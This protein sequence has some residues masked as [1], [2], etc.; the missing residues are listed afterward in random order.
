MSASPSCSN[1]RLMSVLSSLFTVR[2]GVAGSESKHSKTTIVDFCCAS[3]TQDR[4]D[5]KLFSKKL[6][7]NLHICLW[8][9]QKFIVQANNIYIASLKFNFSN[10]LITSLREFL[11]FFFESISNHKRKD[12]NMISVNYIWRLV[13]SACRFSVLVCQFFPFNLINSLKAPSP[14]I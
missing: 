13:A 8:N 9:H 11:I 4:S 1:T 6:S 7:Q 12:V 2:L 10:R 5:Q 14:P 3:S